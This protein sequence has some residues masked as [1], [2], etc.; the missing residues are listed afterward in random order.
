MSPTATFPVR[1]LTAVVPNKPL[2]SPDLVLLL[3][4]VLAA[5]QSAPDEYAGRA[6]GV[7]L[8]EAGRVVA[9]VIRLARRLDASAARTLVPLSALTLMQGPILRLSWTEDQLG[10]QPRLDE[11]LKPPDRL[12][13]G[14]PAAGQSIADRPALAPQGNDVNG[15]ETAKA[16]LEG[17]L[18]GAAFGALAGMAIGGPIGAASLGVFFAAGGSLTGILSEAARESAEEARELD[19]IGTE[20]EGHG[21]FRERLGRLEDRLADPALEAAGLVTRTRFS[22]MTTVAA[23]PEQPRGVRAIA[24]AS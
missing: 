15:A 6:D 10:A 11:D 17:G 14:P 13:G 21:S 23:S 16:G 24:R 4:P 1:T 2:L 9:F 20:T 18:L 3:A 19:V 7:L 5:E 8:D 12:D 22:P